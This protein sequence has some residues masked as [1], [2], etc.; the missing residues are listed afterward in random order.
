MIVGVVFQ[1]NKQL[2]WKLIIFG[3]VDNIHI[4]TRI[5]NIKLAVSKIVNIKYLIKK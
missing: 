4:S 2:F 3:T 5:N 1:C